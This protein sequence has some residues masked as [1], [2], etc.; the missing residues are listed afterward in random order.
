MRETGVRTLVSLS[1]LCG[2]GKDVVLGQF[3]VSV[4]SDPRH[5]P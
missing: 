1:A 5:D 3:S 4:T 2:P